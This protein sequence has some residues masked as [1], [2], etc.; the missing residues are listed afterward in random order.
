MKIR[1]ND[2]ARE[3][4][5]KAKAILD[6]LPE[7]G[8]TAKKT[9]SSSL[10]AD[11]AELVKKYLASKSG[12]ASRERTSA[13]EVKPKLDLSKISKPGDV[14][15]LLREKDKQ[16][17]PPVAAS[18]PAVIAPTPVKTQ[19]AVAPPAT[20]EKPKPAP[21]KTVLVTPPVA[22][23]AAPAAPPVVEKPAA[24]PAVVVTPPHT[25][26]PA[27]APAPPSTQAAAPHDYAPDGAAACVSGSA[28]SG[29]SQPSAGAE[30]RRSNR[31]SYAGWR[32]HA[33]AR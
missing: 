20:P 16:Q 8:V 24:P 13:T 26:P 5:V 2:L 15:R 29:C 11:E 32:R 22:K 21:E 28:R 1:I 17:Q 19:P 7:V 3:L 12:A 10:E 18:K 33:S 30:S 31:S 27:T 25:Q 23:P 4:E 9:H 6:V 14:M